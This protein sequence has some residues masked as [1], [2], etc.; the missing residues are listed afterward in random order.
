VHYD[1]LKKAGISKDQLRSVR[2]GSTLRFSFSQMLYIGKYQ[3]S[4]KAIDI[5]LLT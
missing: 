2:F 1:D 4:Q 5:M 3:K